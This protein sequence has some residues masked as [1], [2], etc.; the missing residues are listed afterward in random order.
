MES[1]G[2][3]YLQGYPWIQNWE[4]WHPCSADEHCWHQYSEDHVTSDSVEGCDERGWREHLRKQS[5]SLDLV[6]Q[7]GLQAPLLLARMES[8]HWELLN[9]L[10]QFE[11]VGAE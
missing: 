3:D 11:D 7:D 10:M 8:K 6:V 2:L 5:F 1:H 4:N 9:Y